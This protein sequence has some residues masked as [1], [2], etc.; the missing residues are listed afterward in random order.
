MWRMCLRFVTH[1]LEYRRSIYHPDCAACVS[2][3]SL[4]VCCQKNC[5]KT[6]SRI[7][8]MSPYVDDVG[9]ICD[10][11]LVRFVRHIV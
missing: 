4:F 8:N 11:M 2:H 7:S 9:T 6:E 3:P 1:C 5:D 10:T